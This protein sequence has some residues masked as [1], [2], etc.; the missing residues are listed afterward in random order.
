MCAYT[1][2][3]TIY[4]SISPTKLKPTCELREV[5]FSTVVQTELFFIF[6]FINFLLFLPWV[7]DDLEF[8]YNKEPRHV[9]GTLGLASDGA[10][11]GEGYVVLLTLFSPSTCS[12]KSM[13]ENTPDPWSNI[14][15]QLHSWLVS[16]L[17][18]LPWHISVQAF[19]HVL[20]HA[21]VTDD[22]WLKAAGP[23]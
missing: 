23:G 17:F 10:A 5:N 22:S 15:L 20:A 14:P 8:V 7:A 1:H 12:R 2:T 21:L 6:L 3:H 9:L 19:A 4:I 11:S 18:H 16:S 13:P